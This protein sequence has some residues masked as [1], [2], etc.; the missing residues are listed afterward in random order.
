MSRYIDDPFLID[1]YKFDLRIYVAVI[2]LHPLKIF[3]YDEGLVRF[4]SEKYSKT[5][6]TQQN[7]FVHLTNYAINKQNVNFVKNE[8]AHIDN[9]GGKW[10]F[11]AFKRYLR[12]NR[13][14]V[15]QMLAQIHD[16]II[17]SI[18]S[19]E[20][21]I[22]QNI[23]QQVP[24]RTNCFELF[25]Y[26]ILLDSKL[27]PYLLEVNLC[28]S[29]VCDSPLDLRIKSALVADLLN[30][31][32]IIAI[33]QREPYSLLADRY[34]K[35]EEVSLK[36]NSK[37]SRKAIEK[38]LMALIANEFSDELRRKG[39]FTMIFPPIKTPRAYEDYFL[40]ERPWNEILY[41]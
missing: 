36:L 19:V 31:A 5:I 17:K 18:L 8:N 14:Q 3:V 29:L 26:D 32:G 1:G 9:V 30:L 25:G 38:E 40:Q 7:L 27:K 23:S 34:H 28:P 2:S 39:S 16:L 24:F 6:D 41:Q 21:I 35:L 13:Y 15:D 22:H 11:T 20:G 10:S 33:E 37:E 4:A 12:D